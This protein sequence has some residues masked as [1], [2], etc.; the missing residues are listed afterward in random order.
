MPTSA[1]TRPCPP[2]WWCAAPA[3]AAVIALTDLENRSYGS[4][5]R[6]GV[7]QRVLKSCL[8]AVLAGA[9]AVS[10][11]AQT[12]TATTPGQGDERP[13]SGAR[14]RHAPGRRHPVGFRPDGHRRRR[15]VLP[16][17]RPHAG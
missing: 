12:A 6:R 5:T 8:L 11:A 16:A 10:A 7:M 3:A 4:K 9:L 2:S 17:R 14:R 15:R 1:A 13:G